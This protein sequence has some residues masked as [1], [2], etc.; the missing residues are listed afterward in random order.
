MST[1]NFI[2]SAILPWHVF[3]VYAAFMLYRKGQVKSKMANMA[4][5]ACFAAFCCFMT[6]KYYSIIIAQVELKKITENH[7][8]NVLADMQKLDRQIDTSAEFYFLLADVHKRNHNYDDAIESL[9]KASEYTSDAKLFFKMFSSYDMLGKTSEGIQYIKTISNI[10]PQN[11]TSR[12]ILLK[13]YES[14][15]MHYEALEVANEMV[16][17]KLKI[18]NPKS[19]QY[20]RGAQ[21]YIDYHN[22][23]LQSK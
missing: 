18:Q 14:A 12:N 7:S 10:L 2:Y 4:L 6:Y 19:L 21:Y 20:Q 16:N 3:V 13:W 15:G 8:A 11:M 9:E 1:V 22:N 23:K 5:S 17:T